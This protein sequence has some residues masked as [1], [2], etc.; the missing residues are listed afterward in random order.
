[1]PLY[2]PA[3]FV[4]KKAKGSLVWDMDN[5]KYIDFTLDISV[6]KLDHSNDVLTKIM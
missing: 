4:V 2:G 5:K 3:A 6:T 1:M